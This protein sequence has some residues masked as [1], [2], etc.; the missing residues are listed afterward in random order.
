MARLENLHAMGASYRGITSGT[1]IPSSHHSLIEQSQC[2]AE[3][4]ILNQYISTGGQPM[5]WAGPQLAMRSR[6]VPGGRRSLLWSSM[7]AWGLGNRIQTANR[8]H[9]TVPEPRRPVSGRA[10]PL[11]TEDA[12]YMRLALDQARKVPG[13][14]R[15]TI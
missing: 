14:D 9:A 3:N 8:H 1:D 10:A 11:E 7:G 5:C 15:A 12:K 2:S 6:L 4:S 13:R